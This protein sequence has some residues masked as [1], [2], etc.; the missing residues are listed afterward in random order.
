MLCIENELQ[1]SS[2]GSTYS[3]VCRQRSAHLASATEPNLDLQARC[4]AKHAVIRSVFRHSA[5]CEGCR[6]T[7]LRYICT[8]CEGWRKVKLHS[9]FACIVPMR[10]HWPSHL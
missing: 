9:S 2:C 1:L 8:N 6:S 5:A 3:L 7:E 4:E 10:Y